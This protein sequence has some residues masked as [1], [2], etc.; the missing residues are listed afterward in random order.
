[1]GKDV[2]KMLLANDPGWGGGGGY[3]AEQYFEMC[4]YVYSISL[5]K[6]FLS[7][8]E[9]LPPLS[10]KA[11]TSVRLGNERFHRRVSSFALMGLA[12]FI[13]VFLRTGFD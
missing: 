3:Y 9:Y 11:K 6:S 8:I 10:Q 4:S 7:L 12:Y 5:S 13:P 1:L 2:R